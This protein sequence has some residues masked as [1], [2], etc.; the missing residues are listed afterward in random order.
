MMCNPLAGPGADFA[1][2]VDRLFG[3]VTI[4]SFRNRIV[5]RSAARV[6]PRQPKMS[7]RIRR[8]KPPCSAG[9]RCETK[10]NIT[11]QRYL[12]LQL[13]SREHAPAGPNQ[14]AEKGTFYRNAS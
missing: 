2:A 13:N 5:C 12:I 7:R 11:L 9:W 10:W 8:L 3:A 6:A 4:V 1:Q 14:I